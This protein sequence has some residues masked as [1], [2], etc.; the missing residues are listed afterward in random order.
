MGVGDV[1]FVLFAVNCLFYV[2]LCYPF[3][4]FGLVVTYVSKIVVG[5][6]GGR[7]LLR[8]I[9]PEWAEKPIWSML[10]GVLIVALLLAIP[11]LGGLFWLV[12]T[13]FG[14]GALWF[15]CLKL[16]ETPGEETVAKVE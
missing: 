16:S 13:L 15:L 12:F 3:L 4:A 10:V 1:G 8:S 6:W 9:K 11:F 14:L 5:F 2:A 7:A